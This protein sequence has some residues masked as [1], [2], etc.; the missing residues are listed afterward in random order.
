[1]QY[2][3]EMNHTLR[4]LTPQ[5]LEKL[6]QTD[7]QTARM[8]QTG[9]PAEF[10]DQAVI[11]G[12]LTA[13]DLHWLAD[14]KLRDAT[15]PGQR[16]ALSQALLHECGADLERLAGQTAGLENSLLGSGD[17]TETGQ[18]RSIGQNLRQ[19]ANNVRQN[20]WALT[21]N[22]GHDLDQVQTIAG[23]IN[24]LNRNLLALVHRLPQSLPLTGED[25]VSPPE[26]YQHCEQWSGLPF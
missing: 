16:P 18:L 8:P 6:L 10:V 26:W 24:E 2:H 3:N 11:I 5:Q 22:P 15:V 9:T 12:H 17:P 1:M 19:L 4:H 23:R 25:G 7:G 20:A 14:A 21:D 13:R